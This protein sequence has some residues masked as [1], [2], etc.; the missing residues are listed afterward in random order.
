MLIGTQYKLEADEMNVILSQKVKRTNK[1]GK[2]YV[3]WK[4]IGYFA[5]PENA[6][7]ELVNLKVRETELK[8]LRTVVSEINNLHK[9]ILELLP[10]RLRGVRKGI[11]EE[12]NRKG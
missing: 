6:L 3:D 1:E 12:S 10:E 2:K 11:K 5:T 4:G 9:I 8:D 7:T